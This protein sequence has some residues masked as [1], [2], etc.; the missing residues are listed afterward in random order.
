MLLYFLEDTEASVEQVITVEEVKSTE[1]EKQFDL[2]EDTD[3]IEENVV[4]LRALRALGSLV[5]VDLL[6][7][8]YQAKVMNGWIIQQG[9]N[10]SFFFFFFDEQ[11]Q[12]IS[13]EKMFLL[14][15][16]SI[17]YLQ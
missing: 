13:V 12:S 7:L 2:N 16:A 9:W 10:F 1:G 6:E 4:D 3:L 11:S 14:G 15:E 8:P 17:S 5:Y